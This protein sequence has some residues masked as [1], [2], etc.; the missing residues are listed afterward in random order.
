MAHRN[1]TAWTFDVSMADVKKAITASFADFEWLGMVLAFKEDGSM[2]AEGVLSK[3]GNENDAYLY[4][5]HKPIRASA[6]YCRDGKGLEYLAEFQ[7]HLTSLQ[8]RRTRVE[9]ITHKPEVIAG[10]T[11]GWLSPHGS[12]NI[13][14]RVEPTSIE[15]YEILLRLGSTLDAK[16]MPALVPPE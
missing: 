9:V 13:Y 4:N 16:G 6:V 15:E 7:L 11:P 10:M 8:E 3:P 1:P 5:H 2:F 12:A 14:V